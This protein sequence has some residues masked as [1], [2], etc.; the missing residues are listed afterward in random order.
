MGNGDMIVGAI[1][2]SLAFV[3]IVAV[4]VMIALFKFYDEYENEVMAA[5]AANEEEV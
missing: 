2:G 4:L 1:M 3:L 5:R